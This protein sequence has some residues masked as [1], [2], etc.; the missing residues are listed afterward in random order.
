M[1]VFNHPPTL[2]LLGLRYPALQPLT[3]TS[4]DDVAALTAGLGHGDGR[5]LAFGQKVCDATITYRS[6]VMFDPKLTA[7]Q[8][9]NVK[10]LSGEVFSM[11]VALPVSPSMADSMNYHIYKVSQD[12]VFEEILRKYTQPSQCTY[13]LDEVALENE[14]GAEQALGVSNFI[15]PI[16]IVCMGIIVSV[17][18]KLSGG[19]HMVEQSIVAKQ[20]ARI[21]MLE[22]KFEHRIERMYTRLLTRPETE[23]SRSVAPQ[24]ALSE[25]ACAGG[26]VSEVIAVKVDVRGGTSVG[27]SGGLNAGSLQVPQQSVGSSGG[28]NAGS[29]Q[30]PPQQSV[31]QSG[32]SP[33]AMPEGTMKT[34][35]TADMLEFLSYCTAEKTA[36]R[37]SS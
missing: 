36:V 37:R 30:V 12:G 25:V 8:D 2:G 32:A 6:A 18:F 22:K 5:R 4:W 33:G 14:E 17:G 20:L 21:G 27:S 16:L 31:A 23:V 13:E 7:A 26:D 28:L 9:C 34:R 11:Q 35:R 3:N 19:E 24:L 29:L 10:Y 1:C 15:A